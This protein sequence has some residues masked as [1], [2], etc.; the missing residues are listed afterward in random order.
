MAS[1]TLEYLGPYRLLNVVNTGQTSRIWQAYDDNTRQF[2]GIK[3]LLEKY[4]R[5]REQINALKWEHVVAGNLHEEHIIRIHEFRVSRGIPY[6]AMEWF[7]APNL[8]QLVRLGP[9]RTDYRIPSIIDQAILA[10]CVLAEQGWVHRDVKPDNFLV[11][12]DN[13]V[14]LID[15]AL[16][17]RIRRGLAR[18]FPNKSRV[19]GTKS[20]MSPEQILGKPLDERSDLYSLGCSIFELIGGRPPYTGTSGNDLLMKHLRSAPPSLEVL[21]KNVTSEFSQLIRS[22]MAKRP[23]NRPESFRDFLAKY[24]MVRIFRRTPKPPERMEPVSDSGG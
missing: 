23:R 20:Y 6:L 5:D 7:S 19:Q 21:N 13:V 2:V 22:T 9:G 16:A 1:T 8:K 18:L 4:R 11:N 24:R 10:M 12:D 15:F 3:V 17:V 14:K